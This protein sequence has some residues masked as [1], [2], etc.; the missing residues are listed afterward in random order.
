MSITFEHQGRHYTAEADRGVSLAIT[1]DFAGEQPAFFGVDPA[2]TEPLQGGEFIGDTDQGGSCNVAELHLI[3]HCHGTHTES[4]AHLS[5]GHPAAPR[6][7]AWLAATVITIAPQALSAT[8]E[9][10]PRPGRDDE[11]VIARRALGEYEIDTPALIVRTKPNTADKPTRRYAGDNPHPYFTLE[12]VDW[13]AAQ[14]VEHLLVDT[15]SIDRGRD[16]GTLPAHRSFW[17]L[18]ERGEAMDERTL[19]RTITEFIFVPD[20]VEDGLYLLNLQLP[21]WNTDA[22]PSRPLIFPLRRVGRQ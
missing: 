18:N 14:G 4:V 15:P 13:L 6:P 7:P 1:L 3:P 10:Y 16:D 12:A 5:A 19:N 8:A 21:D 9:T 17:A 2:R 11:L 22:I 20:P